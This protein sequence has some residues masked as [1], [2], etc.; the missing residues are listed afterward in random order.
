MRGGKFDVVQILILVI[1]YRWMVVLCTALPT[2][3][4][5]FRRI[6]I[7]HLSYVLL[8]EDGCVREKNLRPRTTVQRLVDVVMIITWFGAQ[9]QNN[10]FLLILLA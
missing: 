2:Y 6:G 7:R 4:T 9:Q 1:G 3:L 8:R 5:V 10:P